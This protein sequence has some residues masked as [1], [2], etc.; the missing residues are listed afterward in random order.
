VFVV[1]VVWSFDASAGL[2][3]GRGAVGEIVEGNCMGLRR[4]EWGTNKLL[5][6][7]PLIVAGAEWCFLSG[8][9]ERWIST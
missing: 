6:L 9:L 5:V 1:G 4:I 7:G 8:S 3:E 2:G